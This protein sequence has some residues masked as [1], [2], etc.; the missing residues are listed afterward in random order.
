M[1]KKKDQ[2]CNV[3]EAKRKHYFE[4]NLSFPIINYERLN[5]NNKRKMATGFDTK[6]INGNFMK[7]SFYEMVRTEVR[8]V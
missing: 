7:I 2:K 4:E 3:T 1:Q 8:L 6:E 5:K